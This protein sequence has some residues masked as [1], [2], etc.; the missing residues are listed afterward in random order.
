MEPSAGGSNSNFKVVIRVRPHPTSA[1]DNAES[2]CAIDSDVRLSLSDSVEANDPLARTHA[3]TFDRVYGQRTRQE[4]IY[5]HTAQAAVHSTLQGYNASIIAYGQT[6]GGK[7]YTMEGLSTEEGC[8]I[9]PRAIDD[10]FNYIQQ[11]R[12]PGVRFL[13]RAS[14]LQIYNEVISDLIKPERSNLAIHEDKKKGLFVEGLSEWIVKTPK[15]IFGLMQRGTSYRS[16]GATQMNEASSRSH[17]VFVIIVEQS[18]RTAVEVDDEGVERRVPSERAAD[19][20]EVQTRFR[21]GKLNLV[22]LAGSERLRMSGS[23]GDRLVETKSINKSLSALGNVI[24]ALTDKR[25]DR[26]HVPYRDSKLTRLLEDSL[27]G[28]CKTTM[29]AVISP[30]LESFGESLSTLKFANRAKN[31]RN[32]A[33]INEDLDEKT[34]LRRYERELRKLRSELRERSKLIVDNRELIE[35]EDLRRKA[36]QD[37][38]EALKVLERRSSELMTEKTQ[39]RQL[40]DR[41]ARMQSQ[42]LAGSAGRA[43]ELAEEQRLVRSEYDDKISTVESERQGLEKDK[44]HVDKY[45]RLLVQQRD[46][47]IALTARLT[48][49]DESIVN[50]KEE[51]E[52]YERHKQALEDMLDQRTQR[53]SKLQRVSAEQFDSGEVLQALNRSRQ[54][55][56]DS[57]PAHVSPT[58]GV[59]TLFDAASGNGATDQSAGLLRAS[60]DVSRPAVAKRQEAEAKLKRRVEELKQQHEQFR[61]DA[62]HAMLEKDAKIENAE[63][64]NQRFREQ[65]RQREEGPSSGQDGSAEMAEF[66]RIELLEVQRERDSLTERLHSSQGGLPDTS[67]ASERLDSEETAQLEADITETERLRRHCAVAEKERQALKVILERKIKILVDSVSRIVAEVGAD[68]QAWGMGADRV[69]REVLAI[70]RLT[71]A[72]VE[73][74]KS[75]P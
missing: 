11:V 6:G 40:E 14:Y 44:A 64:E 45:K 33:K 59:A 75:Q 13:V 32:S 50:L 67:G 29:I 8:G 66:L 42:L 12:S 43:G 9:I 73:A 28:N 68:P 5:R 49:R 47:M 63:R 17:A 51:L 48:E 72:S 25:V 74:L 15:E 41:I 37:K 19:G 62:N 57:V 18:E 38:L 58:G 70:Q 54:E 36:E 22:D 10:I 1:P 7:T 60:A 26:T 35:L 61:E 23:S 16:T 27:G 31:I 65:R 53:L 69:R 30:A 39:K 56:A 55:A 71:D 24:S 46:I 3:F 20:A 34:L 4:T 21:V 2:S 52:A